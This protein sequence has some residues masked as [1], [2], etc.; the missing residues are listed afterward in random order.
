MRKLC[1]WFWLFVMA[2]TQGT[3]QERDLVISDLRGSSTQAAP[4]LVALHNG[5]STPRAF[6]NQSRLDAAARPF[7]LIVAYPTPAGADWATGANG[8]DATDVEYLARLISS[9]RADP[10]VADRPVIVTGHGTGGAMALRLACDR[11]DLV[12]G[13]AVVS[14][15]VPKSYVCQRGRPKPAL[16][17]HGTADPVSPHDGGAT[18]LS[19][20]DSMAVWAQ[21]NRCR[22]TLRVSRIDQNKRDGTSVVNRRYATCQAAL[23]QLVVL[24]G[25]HGWP[26]GRASKSG[27]LGPQSGEINASDVAVSFLRPLVGR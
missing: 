8:K 22:E 19:A 13:I 23:T 16:F 2:A 21:R 9:M 14:T 12:A 5:G 7:A 18:S 24:G 6:R 4:L 27:K 1:L 3:A 10:R 17:V 11:P 15:K 26:T 20:A 25:G